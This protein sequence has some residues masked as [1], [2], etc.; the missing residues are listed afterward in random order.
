MFYNQKNCKKNY[1]SCADYMAVDTD[2]NALVQWL[3]V[4]FNVVNRVRSPRVSDSVQGSLL[5]FK[6]VFLLFSLKR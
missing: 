5:S 1:C 6:L 4:N 2:N 3:S